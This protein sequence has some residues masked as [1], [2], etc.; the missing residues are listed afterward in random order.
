MNRNRRQ[1]ERGTHPIPYDGVG[2]RGRIAACLI[3][4]RMEGSR[5]E[6]ANLDKRKAFG[7]E[8]VA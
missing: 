7:T 1:R 2:K 6:T 5:R 3:A 8:K 4:L